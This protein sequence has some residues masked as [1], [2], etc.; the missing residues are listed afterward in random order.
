MS[1]G[2]IVPV[3]VIP[4]N[5]ER[6]AAMAHE[7]AARSCA[8]T[9]FILFW[10]LSTL[11]ASC[12]QNQS[13]QIPAIRLDGSENKNE[14]A[15]M[16]QVFSSLKVH[17]T[18]DSVIIEGNIDLDLQIG[19]EP[20]LISGGG[21]NFLILAP[22]IADS[23]RSPQSEEGGIESLSITYGRFFSFEEARLLAHDYCEK[24]RNAGFVDDNNVPIINSEYENNEFENYEKIQC[25]LRNNR[26]QVIISNH[27]IKEFLSISPR[28]RVTLDFYIRYPNSRDSIPINPS[29]PIPTPHNS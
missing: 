8:V 12:S 22:V 14:I 21:K 4:R 26:F 7:N 6:K 24:F 9:K 13:Y 29:Q 15:E 3:T 16:G 17:E 18:D 27:N 1:F 19:T 28:E 11:T 2:D 10:A 5:S 25:N 20:I 23:G